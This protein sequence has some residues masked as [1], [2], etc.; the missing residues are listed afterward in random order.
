MTPKRQRF[1][2]GIRGTRCVL[3]ENRNR[4]QRPPVVC[5]CNCF[6]AKSNRFRFAFLRRTASSALRRLDLPARAQVVAEDPGGQEAQLGIWVAWSEDGTEVSG[7]DLSFGS[8]A[9]RQSVSGQSESPSASLSALGEVDVVSDAA[10]TGTPL[11]KP[12]QSYLFVRP[13]STSYHARQ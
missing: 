1:K 7:S 10:F 8:A 11:Q 4:T 2:T 3:P 13:G 9:N 6:K 5:S 12:E